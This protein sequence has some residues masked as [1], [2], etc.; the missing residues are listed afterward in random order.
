M[1]LTIR[2]AVGDDVQALASL[3][4]ELGYPATPEVLQHKLRLFAAG[5]HDRVLVAQAQGRGCGV[6]SLHALDL[7]HAPGRLGRITSLAVSRAVRRRGVGSRLLAAAD[8]HF[9][10]QGCVRA[11]VTS[12]DHRSEAHAFYE[13]C[14]YRCDERRFVKVD[15]ER[16]D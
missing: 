10:E 13:Q 1:D 15:A 8:Q 6:I 9:R 16:L 2:D 14:G 12:G 11:E 4:G 3:M 7:F 5:G